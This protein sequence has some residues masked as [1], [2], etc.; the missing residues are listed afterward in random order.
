MDPHALWHHVRIMEWLCLCLWQ[1]C[2]LDRPAWQVWFPTTDADMANC[3]VI[4]Y[5]IQIIIDNFLFSDVLCW[6]NSY[7]KR[8]PH[9]LTTASFAVSKQILHSNI[10]SSFS[11]SSAEPADPDDLDGPAC[12][13]VLLIFQAFCN[14]TSHISQI[15]SYL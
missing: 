4:T 13:L 10:L 11:F 12:S 3:I 8:W 5:I 6:M 15:S 7:Q 1:L 9:I 2:I 14:H